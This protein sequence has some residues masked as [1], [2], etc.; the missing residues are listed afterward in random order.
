MD[1]HKDLEKADMVSEDEMFNAEENYQVY[2]RPQQRWYY[3]RDQ[4][5]NEVAVFRQYDSKF[6]IGSGKPND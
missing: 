5:S 3:L 2:Y 1:P 4:K 6:G